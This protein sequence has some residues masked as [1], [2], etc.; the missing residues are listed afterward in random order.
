MVEIVIVIGFLLFSG[1]MYIGISNTI[2]NERKRYNSGICPKCGSKLKC[3]QSDSSGARQYICT[4][5]NN[6]TT[7]VS[8][9]CVDKN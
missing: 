4:L 7:W 6:Y 9:D 3:F 8:Y 1:L 5:C 2:S